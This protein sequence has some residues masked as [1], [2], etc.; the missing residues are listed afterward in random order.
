MKKRKTL[1]GKIISSYI[2]I[3]I[4]LSIIAFVIII[5]L[6]IIIQRN[7]AKDYE[8][9]AEQT[10]KQDLSLS[11]AAYSKN[12]KFM[13]MNATQ[14]I[15]DNLTDLI[16]NNQI[17]LINDYIVN[18]LIGNQED[19]KYFISSFAVIDKNG[20]IFFDSKNKLRIGKNYK[21]FKNDFPAEYFFTKT[22][23]TKEKYYSTYIYEDTSLKKQQQK[24]SASIRVAN[25]PF[26][27]LS[28][29]FESNFSK[30]LFSAISIEKEK[31]IKALD[32]RTDKYFWTIFWH[33]V[34]ITIIIILVFLIVT[35]A[36]GSKLAH[37]ISSPL[38][39]IQQ[40]LIEFGKGDFTVEVPESGCLETVALVTA[41]NKL[42]K[43]LTS[44]MAKLE[45]E[46]TTRNTIENEIQIAQNIQQSILPKVTDEFDNEN[47]SL[48]SKLVAAKEVAGDFYDFFFLDDEKTKLAFLIADVSGKSISAAFFMCIV[49]TITKSLCMSGI[50]EP[51]E[52]LKK[53]NEFISKDNT[54]YMFTTMFLGF[55]DLKTGDFIYANAGHHSTVHLTNNQT[56]EE[57]GALRNTVLGI[58]PAYIYS[59]GQKHIEHGEKLVLYTDGITEA[60]SQDNKDYGIERLNNILSKNITSTPEII[61]NNVIKDVCNFQDGI[62]FDD[63]TILV[64]QRK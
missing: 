41:F 51:N 32:K 34:I 58:A 28:S 1:K 10:F 29:H 64:F 14:R 33:V 45:S 7:E 22:A 63:I 59:S 16:I 62:L 50:N 25:T 17:N 60:L 35:C 4:P 12:K 52:V 39:K 49:K 43:D 40:C 57:F 13:V 8:K 30:E 46:I 2:Y 9:L 11:Q 42:G 37:L 31:N 24:H 44:Y 20:D 15:T 21:T 18:L 54:Q 48:Y 56:I 47:F 61:C 3:S 36:I 38:S 23:L 55:Y 27:V 26:F 19:R 53:T 5:T 6:V